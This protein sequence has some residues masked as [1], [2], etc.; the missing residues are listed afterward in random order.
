MEEM[1]KCIGLFGTCGA[2]TWR[3]D[4]IHLYQSLKIPF[5]NPQLPEGTWTPGCVAKENYNLHHNCIVLF[6]VLSETTGNGS[7]AEVGFSALAAL[8]RN[9]DRYFIFYIAD[10][11]SDP[12][13]S[14]EA[15]ADSERSRVL[16]KSK[17][18]ELQKTNNG[19]FV[20]KYMSEMMSLSVD[21][22]EHVS[23][24]NKLHRMYA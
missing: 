2:S 14:P 18:L 21:L 19:I 6:P 4:F 23:N 13:A 5:F 11:C 20:V 17:L 22:F 10:K 1:S 24:V 7:L 15:I 8:S 9:P 3:T 12:S 16:V